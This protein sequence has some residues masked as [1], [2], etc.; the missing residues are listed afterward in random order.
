MT[1]LCQDPNHEEVSLRV[2]FYLIFLFCIQFPVYYSFKKHILRKNYGFNVGIVKVGDLW[3][4][5][6]YEK[7]THLEGD[8]PNSV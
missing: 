8:E 2:E 3:E 5:M 1:I 7:S 6:Y 4:I